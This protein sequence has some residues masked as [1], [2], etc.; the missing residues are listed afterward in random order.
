ME[1]YGYKRPDGQVGTRNY[2]GIIPSVFCAERVA[3]QI[4]ALVPGAVLLRHPLGCS[5]VGEDLEITGRTLIAMGRHPNLA[6][7]LVVGLGC[8]RLDRKSVV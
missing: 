6:A 7:V 8:E 5:Q 1:F 4:S 3:E 2:V